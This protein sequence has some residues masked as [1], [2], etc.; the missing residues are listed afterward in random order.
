MTETTKYLLWECSFTRAV[1]MSVPGAR[2]SMTSTQTSIKDWIIS[3]FTMD[4]TILGDDWIERMTNTCWEIWK[5]RCECVFDDLKPNPIKVIRSLQYLNSMT[6]KEMIR[7]HCPVIANTN[8][9]PPTLNSFSIC[10]DASFK[11]ILTV[12]HTGIS[13]IL[14]NSAGNF[15]R[16]RSSYS[17]GNLTAEHAEVMGL[18]EA[19]QW[20][21][22]LGLQHV[23]FE[24]DAQRVVKATNGD[25][26]QVSWE[27]QAIIL[28]I[29]SL[30]S[31]HPL[32][33]C[34]FLKRYFN[35]P[36]DELAKHARSCKAL[37]NWIDNPRSLLFQL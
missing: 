9:M 8:W 32:W 6:G 23:C 16:G 29:I 4:M 13:L 20:A 2:Q 12:K 18:L 7:P 3:W 31:N 37:K 11:E 21:E 15:V 36:A 1:W 34:K 22:E 14:R 30:F 19:T 26:Q 28:D 17:D 27:N 10:C 5:S 35:K 24:L 25:F 33:S